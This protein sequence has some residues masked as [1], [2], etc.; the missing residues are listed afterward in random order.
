M[1]PTGGSDSHNGATRATA[2]R[3]LSAAWARIPQDKTLTT[4]FHIHITAGSLPD[5]AQPN[6]WESRLGT[7]AAPII[8]EGAD[9]GRVAQLSPVNIFN[10]HNLYFINVKFDGPGDQVHCELCT[11]FLLRDVTVTGRRGSTWEVVKYNQ[12][13]GMYIENA[14]ISG[15][16]DNG[17]DNVAVQYGHILD[18]QV[19]NANWCIYQKGGSAYHLVARTEIYDCGESGYAAGQGT[20]LEFMVSPW[21][22]YEAYDIRVENCFLHDVWGA[23][24][25]V[26]RSLH[27]ALEIAETSCGCFIPFAD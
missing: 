21:M 1:D 19:H 26:S 5:S 22:R 25:G 24:L 15:G 13:Q 8:I 17:I 23:A 27:A 12:C 20:G 3:T 14:D 2:L 9:P 4:G 18:S 10:T 11:N 16:D 6:Y 7:A